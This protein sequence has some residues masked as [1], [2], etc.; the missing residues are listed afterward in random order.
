MIKLEQFGVRPQEEKRSFPQKKTRKNRV[1]ADSYVKAAI[2]LGF[3]S[4]VIGFFPGNTFRDF[5]YKVGEPWRDD[6]LTAPFTFSL[7]QR[8]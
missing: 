2:I 4:L 5:N 7:L 3:L 6:D 8:P 1:G